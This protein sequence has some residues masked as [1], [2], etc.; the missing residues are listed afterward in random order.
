MRWGRGYGLVIEL[1]VR[2]GR[3]G[4]KGGMEREG[5]WEWDGPDGRLMGRGR[6]R[7]ALGDE[8]D[9]VWVEEFCRVGSCFVKVEV[10]D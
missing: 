4:E 2:G 10:G 3:G 5:G 8:D 1:E 7:G 9:K 6:G